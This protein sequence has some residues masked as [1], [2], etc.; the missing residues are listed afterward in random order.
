[1]LKLQQLFRAQARGWDERGHYLSNFSTNPLRQ[2]CRW[3]TKE[4]A[5]L[6]HACRAGVPRRLIAIT[7]QR[8]PNAIDMRIGRLAIAAQEEATC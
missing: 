7:H 1:V 2:G 5:D 6:L 3:N 8:V 4:D